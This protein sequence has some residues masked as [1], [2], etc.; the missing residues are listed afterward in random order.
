MQSE[1]LYR[2]AMN[3]YDRKKIQHEIDAR[4]A[5][6]VPD[7]ARLWHKM[8]R[9]WQAPRT[10]NA[11]WLM[12]SANYLFN[13]QGLKWAVDPVFLR[14]R[15]PEA[16]MMDVR[17]D[18]KGLDFILL[19]HAH[20]DHIDPVLWSQLTDTSCHWIVPEPM[21]AFF[22]Q[23]T[24]LR[25]ACYSTAV[26]GKEISVAG[27]TITPFEAPHYEHMPAG[28][29]NHVDETGYLIKTEGGSYLLPGDIRTY[30]TATLA[31]FTDVSAVFAHVFL[32]RSAALVFNPPLLG[33]FVDFI[34]NCHP[35]KVVLSHLYEFGREPEDCW[36]TLHARG[37]AEALHSA[38]S[39]L[40]ILIPEWYQET[41]L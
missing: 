8:T 10:D 28:G 12:Y 29:I 34:L 13:T 30:D 27:A 15:V 19:T 25:A 9:A 23:Q 17:Q 21:V 1:N 22:K 32:G 4:R 33:A 37:A 41:R 18:L 35:Q 14:N 3:Q 36:R 26:P 16:P 5:A 31:P 7:Y 11:V 6:L 20:A 40:D 39:S 24:S 38:E 2:T